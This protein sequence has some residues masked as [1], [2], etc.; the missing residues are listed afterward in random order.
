M[1]S[2]FVF[3]CAIVCTTIN[4]DIADSTNNVKF[5]KLKNQVLLLSKN[6]LICLNPSLILLV[7]KSI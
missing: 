4:N 7:A 1:L 5:S 3:L 6:A 2:G